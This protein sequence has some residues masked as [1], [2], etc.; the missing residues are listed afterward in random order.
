MSIHTHEYIK[1]CIF[2]PRIEIGCLLTLK[3]VGYS[4]LPSYNEKQ[5]QTN[6]IQ[7]LTI[8]NSI[9]YDERTII[10]DYD[11]GLNHLKQK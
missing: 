9:S 2:R 11:Q 3:M 5:D 4:Y 8:Q 10:Y 1:N 7:Y 6:A